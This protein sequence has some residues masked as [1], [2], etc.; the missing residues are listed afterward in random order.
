MTHR[1]LAIAGAISVFFGI[2]ASCSGGDEAASGGG[3]GFHT[4]ASA[5]GVTGDGPVGDGSFISMDAIPDG[6][7]WEAFSPDSACASNSVSA[8][9]TPAVMLF[10][11]DKS[12][13]MNCNP[14]P[15]TVT[16]DCEKKPQKAD[17]ATLSKWE[18]TRDALKNALT[19]LTTTTP[20]PSAGIS[21]FNNGD[22]CGY[23]ENPDVL[24]AG[25]DAT[26]VA[27][28]GL[29][30]DIVQ[31]WGATPIVGAMMRAYAYLQKNADQF[32]GNKFV[33]LLTDGG[34][35]CDPDAMPLLVQKSADAQAIGIRTFV[36]G[37]PG[38]EQYRGFL[39]Q[40]AFNGGTGS[41][42]ACNHAG[43]P[44]DVGDCHMDMTLP[45]TDFA[46]ELAKNLK[47]ISSKALSC[48]FDIPDPADG[49][50]LDPNKVNVNYTP[51]SG[52]AAQEIPRNDNISCNDPANTGW[53]YSTDG[54]KIVLCGAACETVKSDPQAK[55]S[56]VLG[57]ETHTV[58]K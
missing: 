31:P 39:S 27:A 13:S 2:I 38:S 24:I 45:N 10:V 42:P 17:P 22:F 28:I 8:T 3:K 50:V 15:T 20:L 46:L 48:E 4:D 52:G 26:Q 6:T 37:G 44:T 30:L 12:G 53:Q 16:A 40:L 1:Q 47:A 49:A 55:V 5:D 23:S 29:S 19:T 58:P 25:L 34:E 57:C 51:G 36:L 41:N 35:S 33:V 14:P 11:I 18:I 54:T 43:T 9:Q 56:V 21:V 32:K 7:G